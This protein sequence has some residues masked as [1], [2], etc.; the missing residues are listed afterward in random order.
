LFPVSIAGQSAAHILSNRRDSTNVAGP[1]AGEKADASAGNC[2]CLRIVV[3]PAEACQLGYQK[4]EAMTE[5]GSLALLLDPVAQQLLQSKTPARFAY[6][7]SDGTP[8]VVP[9]GFWWNG[10]EVVLGTPPDAPKM[11]VM[12][13]GAKVALT[14]DS[15]GMPYKVLLLRGTVHVDE[16]EGIAP[17]YAAMAEK[18]MG[19]EG[20]KQWCANLLPICPRM[21]RIFITPEW[22]GILDFEKRFPSALERAMEQIQGG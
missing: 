16:V 14:I 6:V 9:I 13:D 4:E 11:K 20:G 2:Q 22:V 3:N 19:V 5:Q 15:D 7:W 10:K 21:V 17:E 18:V 1:W 8:R 12:K